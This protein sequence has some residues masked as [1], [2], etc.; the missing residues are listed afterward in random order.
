MKS[1]ALVVV[2][3]GLLFA[4]SSTSQAHERWVRH[5]YYGGPVYYGAVAP[6]V[7]APPPAYTYS[8][9]PPVIAPSY[10]AIVPAPYYYGTPGVTLGYR[11]PGLRL[12]VRF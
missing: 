1:L 3:L 5:G 9:A 8:Y 7:V 10:P 12:G 6:V 11:G 2:A 4:M